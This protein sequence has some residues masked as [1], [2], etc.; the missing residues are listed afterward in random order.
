MRGRPFQVPRA[1]PIEPRERAAVLLSPR[2]HVRSDQRAP[3]P[4]RVALGG[5]GGHPRSEGPRRRRGH[6]P[7]DGPPRRRRR[8]RPLPGD[9]P[10]GPVPW[11]PREGGRH[12][13]AIPSGDVRHGRPRGIVLLSPDPAEGF[14]AGAGLLRPG[15]TVVVLSA[16]TRLLAP[17]VRILSRGEYAVL[18]EGA[19][20]KLERYERKGWAVVLAV[21]RKG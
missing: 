7:H 18:M 11:S 1:R 6:G 5:A 20:L 19:G 8:D 9:A 2:A 17:L 16:A 13:V 3:V 10:A 14:R 4:A 12:P 21:G 15:G